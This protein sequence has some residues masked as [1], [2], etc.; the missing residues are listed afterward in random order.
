MG[1]KAYLLRRESQIRILLTYYSILIVERANMERKNR[2]GVDIL[3]HVNLLIDDLERYRGLEQK[4][5][6]LAR[7]KAIREKTWRHAPRKSARASN[8]RA[9]EQ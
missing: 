8:L 9:V 5:E 4:E 2:L 3:P 7:L 6:Y 1:G